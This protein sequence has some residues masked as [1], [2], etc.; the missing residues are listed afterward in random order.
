[1]FEGLDFDKDDHTDIDDYTKKQLDGEK[2]IDEV[3]LMK[4]CKDHQF[5]AECLEAQLGDKEHLN[6]SICKITYGMT[7][8]DMP[9][10]KMTWSLESFP[11]NG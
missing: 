7:T 4:K 10:G 2:S 3:V 6:C 9:P 8:G 1:M 11:C 5:H